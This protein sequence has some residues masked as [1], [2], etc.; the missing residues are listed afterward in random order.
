MGFARCRQV[1]FPG[2][3]ATRPLVWPGGDLLVNIDL[4]R[5]QDSHPGFGGG[6][7]RA[8]IL[9]PQCQII[10]GFEATECVAVDH[11]SRVDA[12]DVVRWSG[13]GLDRLTGKT[14]RIKFIWT[15]GHLYSFRSGLPA[16]A[17][18]AGFAGY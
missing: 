16:R 12:C 1:R 7:L 4:R 3:V 5:S 2:H 9:D 8:E 10:P 17:T 15:N 13:G 18:A 6:S 11:D 14:M